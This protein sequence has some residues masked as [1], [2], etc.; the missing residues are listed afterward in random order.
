MRGGKTLY[1]GRGLVHSKPPADKRRFDKEVSCGRGVVLE[2]REPM[3]NYLDLRQNIRRQVLGRRIS[4]S[5][6]C[7]AGYFSIARREA[8]A[9]CLTRERRP[10]EGDCQ[11]EAER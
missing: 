6:G 8:R 9:L 10:A 5:L 2:D 11:N 7:A 4:W 3:S 1:F